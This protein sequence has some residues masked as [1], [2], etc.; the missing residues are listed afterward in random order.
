[1]NRWPG[2]LGRQTCVWLGPMLLF[3]LLAAAGL[4]ERA[5]RLAAAQSTTRHDD[6]ARRSPARIAD[7]V[8]P[9]RADAA[10]DPVAGPPRI[11]ART[12]SVAEAGLPMPRAP[13]A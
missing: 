2:R 1:V 3:V 7:P 12:R 13:T 9:H 8:Q 5:I 10:I 11:V 4:P 6:G